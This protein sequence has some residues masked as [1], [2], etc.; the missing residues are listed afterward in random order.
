M[1]AAFWRTAEKDVFLG[2]YIIIPLGRINL[3]YL[4]LRMQF[5]AFEGFDGK[6]DFLLGRFWGAVVSALRKFDGFVV[7]IAIAIDL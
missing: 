5:V 7:F 3:G 6:G 4:N 2:G 1:M